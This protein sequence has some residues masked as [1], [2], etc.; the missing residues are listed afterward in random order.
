MLSGV[1]GMFKYSVEITTAA[2]GSSYSSV[3]IIIFG[4]CSACQ[5]YNNICTTT[6]IIRTKGYSIEE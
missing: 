4:G 5:K 3:C 6:D 2:T 1:R